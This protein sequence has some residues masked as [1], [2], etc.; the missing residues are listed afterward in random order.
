MSFIPA[1]GQLIGA[2]LQFLSG[3]LSRDRRSV[4]IERRVRVLSL[5]REMRS[6]GLTAAE[7][8]ELERRLTSED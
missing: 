5:F 8:R 2:L 7:L 1:L 6:A 3:L 4:V